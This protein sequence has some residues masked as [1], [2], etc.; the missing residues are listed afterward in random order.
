MRLRHI[1]P[2]Q[3]GMAARCIMSDLK[4]VF[5]ASNYWFSF[6][7]IPTFFGT[8]CDPVRR[9]GMQPCLVL[10]LLAMAT[11]LHSSEAEMSEEGRIR[12]LRFRDEAQAALEASISSN[13]IDEAVVQAAWVRWIMIYMVQ[14]LITMK[15]LAVFEVCAHPKH[16]GTR[17]MSALALLDSLIRGLSLT[18]LDVDDTDTPLFP[19]RSV[20]SVPPKVTPWLCNDS[21]PAGSNFRSM[22]NHSTSFISATSTPNIGCS[23]KAL[24]LAANWPLTD[25]HVP[26]WGPT[27]TWHAT[28][29]AGEIKKESC[30]RLCW[31][32]MTLAAGYVS[33]MSANREK[34]VDLFIANP[35]NV[36]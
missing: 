11:F 6:F 29:N 27:P 15:V 5:R 19:A 30:R 1:T 22:P 16:S 18:L 35:A 17:T 23:C 14:Q 10:A 8:F 31:S 34:P 9:E 3:R 21:D 20:P 26:L 36:S 33:Y 13:W 24:T 12:A 32:S 4:F 25:E 2:D 28:W 7:H